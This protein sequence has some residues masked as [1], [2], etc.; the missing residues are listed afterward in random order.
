VS[1][2]LIIAGHPATVRGA[3]TSIERATQAARSL[4]APGEAYRIS[5]W[6]LDCPVAERT[7]WHEVPPIDEPPP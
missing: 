6:I 2:Y 5:D 7:D 3:F 4:L 1:V